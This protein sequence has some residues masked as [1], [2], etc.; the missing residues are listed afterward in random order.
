MQHSDEQHS[1]AEEQ[2]RQGRIHAAISRVLDVSFIKHTGDR[3]STV[4]AITQKLQSTH[5]LR[6]TDRGWVVCEDRTGKPLDLQ[7]AVEDALMS[8]R[9]LVDPASVAEAVRDGKVEIGC[10]DDMRTVQQKTTFITKFGLD[11]YT[12]LPQHRTSQITLSKDLTSDEYRSLSRAQKIQ[13][14][15]VVTEQELGAILRRK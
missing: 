7:H 11:A 2:N 12:K 10:K 1:F 9:Y 5:N 4:L 8:D 14:M 13:L 15:N 6:V 3:A